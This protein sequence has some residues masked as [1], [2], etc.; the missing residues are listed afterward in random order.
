MRSNSTDCI[1][2]PQT[3]RIPLI[4]NIQEVIIAVLHSK[5]LDENGANAA[6]YLLTISNNYIVPDDDAVLPKLVRQK[7]QKQKR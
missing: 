6:A 1:T 3:E 4:R 7:Q 5:A 2:V